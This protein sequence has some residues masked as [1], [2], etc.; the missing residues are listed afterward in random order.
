MELFNW[1]ARWESD[2]V[3]I[4]EH[5][6]VKDSIAW[7]KKNRG[8]NRAP[9][10]KGKKPF[11]P[12]QCGREPDVGWKVYTKTDLEAYRP[13]GECHWIYVFAGTVGRI[14]YPDLTWRAVG[15]GL[16]TIAVGYRGEAE[17]TPQYRRTCGRIEVV[18]DILMSRNDENWTAEHAIAYSAFWRYCS[19]GFSDIWTI[20]I[21]YVRHQECYDGMVAKLTWDFLL[22]KSYYTPQVMDVINQ[23]KMYFD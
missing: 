18:S 4:L 12:Y 9:L 23:G 6:K 8:E 16:H 7:F 10:F 22:S 15:E 3:P 17:G 5:P 2:V 11:L 1:E 14:L 13:I 19:R 21:D 20:N